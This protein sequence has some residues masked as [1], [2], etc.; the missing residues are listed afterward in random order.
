MMCFTADEAAAQTRLLR[1][2]GPIPCMVSL[3]LGHQ[4]PTTF[5]N[6]TNVV[7]G[8]DKIGMWWKVEAGLMKK[9]REGDLSIRW[10]VD[11]AIP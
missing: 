6:T 4:I 5:L 9:R 3:Y 8:W 1:G 10:L 11:S 7:C 2:I